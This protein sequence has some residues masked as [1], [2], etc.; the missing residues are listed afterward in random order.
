MTRDE[1]AIIAEA[2]RVERLFRD[3]V[4]YQEEMDRVQLED[5]E[6][7]EDFLNRD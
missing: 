4:D 1:M 5:Y 6:N 3:M 2:E 7:Y